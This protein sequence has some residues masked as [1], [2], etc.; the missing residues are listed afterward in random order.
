MHQRWGPLRSLHHCTT[1]TRSSNTQRRKQTSQQMKM[2]SGTRVG[3]NMKAKIT[4]GPSDLFIPQPSPSAA[5]PRRWLLPQSFHIYQRS[6]SGKNCRLQINLVQLIILA[7][8]CGLPEEH[9][10][11]SVSATTAWNFVRQTPGTSLA[12]G[13]S[14]ILRWMQCNRSK[15][16]T[17]VQKSK[18]RDYVTLL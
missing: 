10:E 11:A 8:H 4:C 16:I 1:G 6:G 18:Y 17:R 3:K 15:K 13:L 5:P 9:L 7:A 12:L 2:P 14:P